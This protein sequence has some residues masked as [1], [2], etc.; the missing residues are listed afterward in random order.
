MVGMVSGIGCGGC[1][2]NLVGG[3]LLSFLDLA[4]KL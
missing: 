3:Y 1:R 4:D 2:L